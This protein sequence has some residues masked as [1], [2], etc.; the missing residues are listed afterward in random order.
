MLRAGRRTGRDFGWCGKEA[1]WL[2]GR[3]DGKEGVSPGFCPGC[4]GGSTFVGH[5]MSSACAC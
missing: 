2:H 1:L 5:I 3:G 4:L